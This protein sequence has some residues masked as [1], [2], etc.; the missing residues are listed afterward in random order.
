MTINGNG[1]VRFYRPTD[2]QPEYLGG[3]PVDDPTGMD[4]IAKVREAYS[5]DCIDLQSGDIGTARD[6]DRKL[7]SFVL[8]RN[9]WR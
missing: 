9:R 8:R 3:V 4:A 6:T 7:R 5:Y 1:F 2:A